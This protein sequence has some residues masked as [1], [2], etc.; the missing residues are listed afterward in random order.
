MLADP[1]RTRRRATLQHLPY[2]LSLCASRFAVTVVMPAL[3]LAEGKIRKRT[4]EEEAEEEA[5]SKMTVSERLAYIKG[6]KSMP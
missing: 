3:Q 4:P 1:R 6:I 5:L 2:I